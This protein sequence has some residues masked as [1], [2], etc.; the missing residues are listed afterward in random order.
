MVSL[1]EESQ[2]TGFP[3]GRSIGEDSGIFI[4]RPPN[5]PIDAELILDD[6]EA[7]VTGFVVHKTSDNISFIYDVNG[8]LV[9]IVELPLDDVPD[10]FEIVGIITG[11]GGLI[12]GGKMLATQGFKGALTF[13]ARSLL[14]IVIEAKTI[15]LRNIYRYRTLRFG[16]ALNYTKTTLGHMANPDRA[17]P[18]YILKEAIRLGKQKADRDGVKGITEYTL[19]V[20]HKKVFRRNSFDDV[21]TRT[22]KKDNVEKLSNL[23]ERQLRVVVR[24]KDTTILHFGFDGE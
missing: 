24:D 13:S 2:E 6:D 19:T 14:N 10:P 12:S 1:S 9:E 23:T 20:Y 8:G 5:I 18:E 7:A 3:L 11:V 21:A 16:K 15:T 4:I 17:I 22:I